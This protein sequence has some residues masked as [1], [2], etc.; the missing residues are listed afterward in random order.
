MV[1]IFFLGDYYRQPNGKEH[2]LCEIFNISDQMAIGEFC[3]Y[4]SVD[5]KD[6]Y[7]PVFNICKLYSNL[8]NNIFSTDF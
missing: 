4:S 1:S 8:Q 7:R 5:E 2:D 3:K 6:P